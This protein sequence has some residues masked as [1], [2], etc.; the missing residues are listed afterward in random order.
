MGV[1]GVPFVKGDPR[2]SRKGR[3]KGSRDKA[4]LLREQAEDL[5]R[6]QREAAKRGEELKS[7]LQILTE[8]ANTPNAS[9]KL[10][11][12]A[13][14]AAAPYV[15]QRMPTAVVVTGAM[16]SITPEQLASLPDSQL[17]QLLDILGR[18]INLPSG[19][20]SQSQ[21]G[22]GGEGGGQSGA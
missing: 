1:R 11:V 10:K 13:A 21:N 5:A 15:H 14:K 8:I 2:I 9:K 4:A 6:R 7:P 12:Q 16:H 22:G 3:K 18:V 19:I 20:T 17:N